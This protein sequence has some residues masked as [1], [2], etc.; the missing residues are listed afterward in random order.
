MASEQEKINITEIEFNYFDKEYKEFIK[1]LDSVLYRNVIF[2]QQKGLS[3][4]DTNF[5]HSYIAEIS[6]SIHFS[7]K[8]LTSSYI[9]RM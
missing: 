7:V 4:E 5:I 6:Q 3:M 2:C 1:S 9:R 8:A